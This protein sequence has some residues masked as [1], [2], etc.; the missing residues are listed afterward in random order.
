M[1]PLLL[2][3]ACAPADDSAAAGAAPPPPWADLQ[4]DLDPFRAMLSVSVGADARHLAAVAGA[5]SLAVWPGPR[6]GAALLDG[7]YRLDA[8]ARC[9]DPAPFPRLA[10]GVDRQGGC[11]E[12]EVELDR[13]GLGVGREVLDVADDPVGQTVSVLFAGGEVLVASTELLERN[14]LDWLRLRPGVTLE[15]V[16]G[17]APERLAA[18][19]GGGWVAAAGR[20][21]ATFDALGARFDSIELVDE[22]AALVVSGGE[23]WAATSGGAVSL[24]GAGLAC[25]GGAGLAADGAGGV[26]VS[27][28]ADARVSHVDAIGVVQEEVAVAGL[29]GAAALNGETGVVYAAVEEGVAELRG[30]AE[31]A[32]HA[33]GRPDALVVNSVGELS[34]LS[35]GSVGVY[36][37]ETALVGRP[38]LSMWVAAFV[39][40][41]RA[42]ASRVACSGADDGMEERAAR[43]L[44]NRALLDDLPPLVAL[45]VSPPVAAHARRCKVADELAEAMRGPRIEVGALFH[46]PPDCADQD[47]L[48]AAVADEVAALADLD[49]S[50]RFAAGAAGWETGGDWVL[51]VQRAGIDRHAFVGLSALPEV[52]IDDPRG[53]EAAPWSGEAASLP[54]RT[55]SAEVTLDDDP[56]GGFVLIPGS[57]LAIFNAA[58][59]AGVLQAECRMVGAG[60]GSVIDA[61]DVAVADLLLHRAVGRRG[62]SGESTW[63][64]HLP[65]IEEFSYVEGCTRSDA[66]RWSGSGCQAEPLQGWLY[67]VHARLVNAGVVRWGCPSEAVAASPVR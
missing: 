7:R 29:V 45:A 67:D 62:N 17:E 49:V 11:P 15:L 26:W 36:V 23:V 39:E 10:D 57:T 58:D 66:G 19:P 20:E 43:A 61:E 3:A 12:G 50:P 18:L 34:V 56:G 1:L 47:C 6:G 30:G 22:V 4:A 24:G 53:K 51:A 5:P 21:V 32:R 46:D 44:D 41:P 13:T 64:F 33:V 38:P 60:G 16:S 27:C 54:W 37:D 9:L 63:Y 25:V 28:P 65:A 8:S 14:P 35:A 40:N 48:D 59:C 52:G 31:V 55:A 2:L 42:E